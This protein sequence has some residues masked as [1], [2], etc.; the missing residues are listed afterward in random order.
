MAETL[1]VEGMRLLGKGL[2]HGFLE[3][4]QLVEMMAEVNDVEAS[5]LIWTER[6]EQEMAGD[7][8]QAEMMLALIDDRIHLIDFLAKLL[9][10]LGAVLCRPMQLA[11]PRKDGG[12]H[13]VGHVSEGEHGHLQNPLD[14]GAVLAGRLAAIDAL[15]QYAGGAAAGEHQMLDELLGVPQALILAGM[16]LAPF[17]R[18]A[19]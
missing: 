18:L 14:D 4:P 10:K 7:A 11:G 6:A 2:A 16:Q 15:L 9:Q 17:R 3:A 12:G 5:P 1:C 19:G 8:L 13:A